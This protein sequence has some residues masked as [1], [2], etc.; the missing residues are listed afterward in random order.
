MVRKVSQ[1]FNVQDL[2]CFLY[3]LSPRALLLWVVFLRPT[4]DEVEA[5][6]PSFFGGL[7]DCRRAY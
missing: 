3:E 5:Q 1:I 6:S 4:D 7:S 2:Y